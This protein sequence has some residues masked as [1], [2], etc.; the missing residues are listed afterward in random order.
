MTT[1]VSNI[2]Q[3]TESDSTNVPRSQRFATG[4]NASGYILTGVDVVSA[5]ST[6]FTAQVCETDTS[7]HPTST[8]TDLTAPA[9]FAAGTMS[10]TAQADT[11]LAKDTTYAVVLRSASTRSVGTTSSD[12]EDAG[13][14]D[15]WSIADALEF[16]NTSNAWVTAS[17]GGSL[18]IAIKGYAATTPAEPTGFTAAVGNAGGDARLGPAGFGRGD[19]PPRVPLQDGRRLSGD[20]DDDHRQRAVRGE[21]GRVRRDGAHQR[22]GAHLFELRAANAGGGSGTV[23][24]GPV[25]P[26]PGIWD[27]TLQVRDG[28]LV[29]ISGVDDCA[30]ATVANL[31]GITR[32]ALNGRNIPKIGSLQAGDFSGLTSLDY[33]NL[34]FNFLAELPD[35]VFSDLSALTVLSLNNNRFTELPPQV[36]SGLS[37]LEQ[38]HLASNMLAEFPSGVFSSLS[39]LKHLHL[40]NNP[41]GELPSGAFSGLPALTHLSLA[42]NELS[43]LPADVFSGLSNLIAIL[44]GDC[45]KTC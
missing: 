2:G 15:G 38:L 27:R 40:S 28:I 12:D 22:G 30:A 42:R 10:F 33:L 9:S 13:Q 14:A 16:F 18:R 44:L 36:F 26:T 39:N 23:Q 6:G 34:G 41:F 37:N 19:H 21:R 35:G 45:P 31:R 4:S 7:G 3:G 25:T 17:G 8:C 29:E 1:L 43:G 20:V 32:L 24:A 5:S 11:P